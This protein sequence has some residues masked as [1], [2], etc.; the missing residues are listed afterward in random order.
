[1]RLCCITL[2]LLVV[3]ESNG[4]FVSRSSINSPGSRKVGVGVGV[5]VGVTSKPFPRRL[6]QRFRH[7][8]R[9]S[10]SVS[11]SVS[12]HNRLPSNANN[13]IMLPATVL[14]AF[15]CETRHILH[16]GQLETW[17]SKLD[18]AVESTKR[19]DTTEALTA[20]KDIL[21]MAAKKLMSPLQAVVVHAV[22]DRILDTVIADIHTTHALQALIDQLTN[23][24][25]SFVDHYFTRMSSKLV[26]S[27]CLSVCTSV[28]SRC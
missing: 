13:A 8:P 5:G 17:E 7:R 23:T 11:A 3:R 4:F 16:H 18:E 20:Y 9:A 22:V 24:H 10:T 19:L 25:I 2:A 27:S 1:V 6:I 14:D 12:G 28:S 21:L 15:T 26:I